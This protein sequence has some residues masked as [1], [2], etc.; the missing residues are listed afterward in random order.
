MRERINRLAKGIIDSE[1]PVIKV[2]PKETT[3]VVRSGG[4]TRRELVVT[5]ENNLHI[6]GLAYSSNF[7]VRLLNGAFGGTYNHLVYEVNTSFLEDGDVIKGAFYLVT[8]GGEREVPYSFRVELSTSGKALSDLKTAEDFAA[9]AKNDY[10]TALR[11]FEYRDFYEAPF[12]KDLHVRALYGGLK[13]RPD[14]K[15]EL[16]EFLTGLGVKE[17]VKLSADESE[18]RFDE[19]AG[20]IEECI[21]VTR[22]CWGYVSLEVTADCDFIEI[23]VR[24]IGDQDFTDDICEI[25]YRIH[26]G[27]MHQGLNQGRIIIT[28][29]EERF[30]VPVTAMV[31]PGGGISAEDAYT[32][33]AVAAYLHLRLQKEAGEYEEAVLLVPADTDE[34]DV[35]HNRMLRALDEIE[36]MKGQLEAI[37]LLRAEIYLSDGRESQ[38]ALLMDECREKILA[39][40]Q[41]KLELYCYYQYLRLILQPDEYQKESLVRLLRKYLEENP[42]LHNLFLI[43]LKLDRRM[44]ENPGGALS[45]M[46]RQFEAGMRSPFLY[47]HACRLLSEE[48]DLI[49][50]I[51]PFELQV[52]SFGARYGAAGKEFALAAARLTLTSRHFNRLHYRALGRLYEKYPEKE[53]LEAVCSILIRGESRSAESFKWY[54]KGIKEGISLT[55]LYEYYLYALPKDYRYLLPKEVLL[56]F[57]Y[58]G[59]ELDRHSRALLYKNVLVYLK[60]SDPLYEA[61][62]RDIEKFATEQLFESRIGSNLAV[63]YEHMIYKDVIDLPMAKV[64]PSILR[65]YRVECKN[66]KMKYV[67]VCYEELQEEDA[68]LLDDGVAYVPLFSEHS[69]L[70]FQD[71]F[72]NRYSTVPYEKTPVMDKPDL[73]ARCFELYPDHPML[74]LRAC[75]E[76]LKRGIADEKE[77]EMLEDAM[78][79]GRLQ[80]LYQRLLLSRIIEYYQHIPLQAADEDS[81]GG[82]TYLV[83]LDKRLLTKEERQGICETLI[84]RNYIEEAFDMIREFGCEDIQS[85]R[86]LKL[87]TRMILKNLFDEDPLLLHLSYRV[88]LEGMSDSVILDYL[89]EHYNGLTNQM[90]RV[91]L[92]GI[93]EHVETYDLEERLVAQMMFSGCTETIDRVF[94][95]YM[96]KKKTSDN[97]VRAYFT[98]KSSEY[99]LE[100]KTPDDKVFAYLEGAVNSSADKERIPTIYLLALTKYYSELSSLEEEQKELLRSTTAVLLEAGLVFPYFKTLAKYVPMPEDIMD[101]AMIQYHSDRNAR[102]DFE[103][104]ILPDE[105]EYH[106]EDIGRTYQG[107]FVKKKVLFEG[108]IMEYRISELEDGQWV[109]KKEGSVS[110]DAVSAAGD[111]ESRFACLNEMSLCLSLKDEEGLKKRMREYLTKN[112]AA[113]ELFPLM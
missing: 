64:L 113:E 18:W 81:S 107:I 2:T 25:V 62:E 52:L 99:F 49:R 38:A 106:C 73:E 100:D 27:R 30:V 55:R 42:D 5:S 112:A 80:P 22:S 108:E 35:P 56:Y 82:D 59:S 39:E 10:E 88:F 66:V 14:R 58:G 21:T 6:K 45:M 28:G 63:I 71:A 40:R 89:C 54:E 79:D 4:A 87:C 41:E 36:E 37:K 68:F 94:S 3:D 47:L 50:S 109:L 67:I 85:K 104:R 26:P 78:E 60:E 11:L 34:G 19:P 86:L 95:L 16:E 32:K 48:P 61:Y 23:P 24:N 91:L 31:N 57:S 77:A 76:V 84:S 1:V 92:Q 17:P 65:S 44:S 46:R 43:L 102:I 83:R 7:R 110:C 90:Y 53:I 29:I 51:G 101:K 20:V 75:D 74:R 96:N 8:N 13:G 98:I 103:V 105:E 93:S 12:M 33:E 15:K 70:L 9:T 111:T 69:I 72:G 97:I